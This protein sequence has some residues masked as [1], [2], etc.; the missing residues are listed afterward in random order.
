MSLEE[1]DFDPALT[2]NAVFLLHL[3]ICMCL[4]L[5]LLAALAPVGIKPSEEATPFLSEDGN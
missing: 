3:C 2:Q 4:C 5:G 1:Q